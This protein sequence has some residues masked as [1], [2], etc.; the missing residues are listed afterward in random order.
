MSFAELWKNHPVVTG[1]PALLDRATYEN[2]CAINLSAALTRSGIDM[3]S[4]NGVWSWQKDKP[5][6]AIRAQELANWLGLAGKVG[7]SREKFSA[8]EA[9]GNVD[10]KKGMMRRTGIVFVQNY[11]GPS[12]QG[13]HIDL[14]NGSR[15]TGVSSWARLNLRIG[16][17]G[18]HSFTSLSDML[19]AEQVW[20]WPVL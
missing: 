6:Y 15:L 7:S 11:Y 16:R 8:P 5:K 18:V 20:F 3:K 2:Q 14:W 19:K 17:F 13:D 4:Y 1:E 9:F 10:G 12:N